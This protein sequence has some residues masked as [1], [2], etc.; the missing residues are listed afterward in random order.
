M[1]FTVKAKLASAFGVVILLSMIAGAVG[2]MKL[3]DMVGTTELLVS[4]AGRMEKAAELKEGVLFLVRAEKNSILAASDAE[5]EQFQAD[6]IKNRDA[7]TKSKD[8][9]YTAASESGKKLMENFNVAFAKLNAYQDETVRLAKTD[10]PKA[11]DRSMHD[12]RKVVADAI[13]AADGY[14]K[15]VKKNMAEQAEQAK[16]DGARAEML[17]MSLVIASLLIAAVAATWIALNISRALAQAVGLADAVAIGDLS[18]KIESSSNDEIGDL[19]KSL[20]AMTVN[21]NATAALANQ[22][23]QGDLM[24]EAKPLSDKD[25]LGL[26]LERMVEKLRQIV[27]EALTA[28]QNVS[29]GSQELSAS[30]EQLSQGATE[31]ASSAEEASSSMEE[32]ASNVKQNADNANQTEKIAAQSAKDAEASG[33]AVGRAVNAMQTIAEKIT[34][35]QEIARQTD[36]LAL[37]AAVEAARAGEHGKGFAVVASEVRKLAERSQAAAAEIGTLSTETV[38]VAQ[39]AGNMLSKLV[40]DIKRTAELVE[41]ITAACRE[42][43]VGSAQIN[44]AIQQLDKV[45]QQ[46]AS[47]S[48]QVSSTSEELASQAEQLQSTIAYFRIEQGRSQA[49][50]PIDRAVSQLRAK[51]ATMAAVERPAKKPQARPARAVKA[52]GGGGFAFDMNDG[53]DDRDADFQR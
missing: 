48:E 21:L 40:P 31:Q 10:K 11:L 50:A 12:G 28:A 23:A 49:A 18:H 14:I 19:I 42:Q 39:E 41:E 6:L 17:L 38:K 53:E 36:L 45:G 9:I 25:T 7:I 8:E 13:E 27:S 15:N 44:E 26:A 29:A 32:M 51:A 47:A 24:V 46:N 20:N 5:H 3:A 22:I 2:Y 35:V 4:R 37:N 16:Q 52:A 34:I 30:A 33:A 43:D 1:R